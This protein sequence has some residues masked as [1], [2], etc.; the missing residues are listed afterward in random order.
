MDRRRRRVL[1]GLLLTTVMLLVTANPQPVTI[2]GPVDVRVSWLWSWLTAPSAFAGGQPIGPA[3]ES[4]TAAGKGHYVGYAATKASG[5]AGRVPDSTSAERQDGRVQQLT[6]PDIKGFEPGRSVR[7]AKDSTAGSDLFV[8]PDGSYTREVSQGTVN[9]QDAKGA[10]QKIDAR[11]TSVGERLGQRANRLGL[12]F[13]RRG[14]DRRLVSASFDGVGFGYSLQGASGVPAQTGAY[15]VTYAG[16]LPG[17]DVVVESRESGVKE[18]IVLQRRGAVHEWVFPLQLDGLVAAL[19]ADGGVVLTDAKGAVKG[20][21]PPGLMHDSKFDTASGEF[22]TSNAVRYELVQ[23][24]GGVGLKVIADEQWLTAP[25]RVYPVTVDPTAEFMNTSDTYMYYGNDVD[26]SGEDNLAVGTWDAGTHRGKALMAFSGFSSTFSGLRITSARLYLFLT[27]QGSCT[28]QPYTVHQVNESWSQST[29]R[30]GS[31]NYDGPAFSSA[32]GTQTPTNY[33]QACANTGGDRTVGEWTSV[34]LDK[35]TLDGWLSGTIPNYGL[36][37][38]A[39]PTQTADFKRFTSRN[40]PSGAVCDS[41][42]CAPFLSVS[43]TPNKAPQI[44]AQYPP[45]DYQATSLTPELLAKGHD[46]DVWPKAMQYNFKVNDAS[47]ALVATSGWTSSSSWTVPAGKLQWSKTY[48]WWVVSYDGWASSPDPLN[49]AYYFPLSTPPPQPLVTSGLSQ[50]GGGRG[51]EPSVGNYTTE[52]MDAQVAT[53]GPALTIQR[54]YN[55]RDP[56]TGSAF[57]AGWSTVVDA[58]V[59]ERYTTANAKTAVI[60]YPTGT[61]VAFGRNA[62]G[63]F[64]PPSGRFSVLTAI[65]GGYSLL[66]KDGTTYLFTRLVSGTAGANALYGL[67]SIKDSAGRALTFAYDAAGRVETMTSASGRALHLTWSTPAGAS[68]AHVATVYT[69]PAVAGDSSSVSIWSYAYSGDQ[70]T[71]VCPPT[72]TT[73]CTTYE[74]GTG[75]QYPTALL[76]AGPRSY[77]RLSEAAGVAKAASTVLDNAGTDAATFKNV[78]LGQAGSLP[79]SSATAAGFNGTSSY[80]EM[81]AKLVTAASYQSLSMWFKTTTPEG[82]LFSYQKDPITNGTTAANYVPALYVGTSGKLHAEFWNGASASAIASPSPVTDGAWHHVVLAAAGDTQTLY[83]DGTAVGTLAGLIKLADANSTAHEYVGAGFIGGSWPD[84]PHPS[85]AVA[86]YFSG[87]ISDVAL[88]D[89]TLT[90]ADV[91]SLRGAA[92]AAAHPVTKIIRPSGATAAQISYDPVSGVVTQVIDEHNGTWKISNPTVAG[93]SQ[94]YAASVLSGGPADYLRMTET[95]VSEAVNEVNGGVATYNTVTLGSPG[96]FADATAAKFNGTASYVELP[97]TEVPGTAPNSVSM[98]FSMPSGSTKGGVLYAYQSMSM[99]D[100]DAAGSWVPAL[101]VGVDGKLRGAFWTGSAANVLTT[102]ASVADG[103]WHHVALAASSTSQSLYLDGTLVGTR[104]AARVAPSTTPVYA[105]LGAG[106]WSSVWTGYDGD[107]SGYFPGSIGE[108]AFFTSQLTAAQ[109]ADQVAAG[110]NASATAAGAA[111]AKRIVVTD[112]LNATTTYLYDVDNGSRQVAEIWADGGSERQT[113]YGYKDGFLRTVTD[114]NGNVTTSEYDGRGNTVSEQTCQD[115]S[116]GRCSTVY[117]SYFLNSASALDPRNDQLTEVRDGRSAGPTDNTYVTKFEYDVLGNKT[118]TTDALGRIAKTD[119][120]DGTT[121][122]AADGGFAPAGLPWRVT[123]PGGQVQTTTYFANGDV[124]QVTDPAQLVTRLGYD[125]LGRVVSKTEISDGYPNGV[126]TRVVYDKLGRITQQTDPATT[127]RVTGAVHTPVTTTTYDYD[128]QITQQT[129]GDATG[130][131]AARTL[132]NSYDALGHIATAT[133]AT[134]KVTTFGYDLYGNLTREVDE[135]GVETRY[136][137]DANGHLLTSTLVGYTGDPNNPVSARD[138]VTESRAY[139]PAGRLAS[140][141]DAMGFVTAFLYTDNNL[142]VAVVKKNADGSQSYIAEQTEYD[143]AGNV[144]REVTNNNATETAYAVDAVGRVTEE[145]L[146]PNGVARKTLY[147]YNNDDQVTMKWYGDHTGYFGAV[148][149]TYD[150]AGRIT[151]DFVRSSGPLSPAG[152]WKLNATKGTSAVDS[153]DHDFTATATSGVTWSG[154]AA[155]FNG[156]TGWATTS[157]PVLDTTQSFSVMAWV[158]L[159]ANSAIQSVVSQDANVDSGFE[160]QYLKTENRWSFTRNLTDTTAASSSTAQ[161]TAA[162]TLNTWTHLV[163]VYNAADGKMTLYVNGAA[164]GTAADTTPIASSGSLAIGRSKYN[165]ATEAPFTGSIAQVQVYQRPLSASDVSSLYGRGW[166]EVRALG[167]VISSTSHTYDQRGL[168]LSEKDPL[169]N[170]EYYEYDESD[171]L[172]VTTSAP[173]NAESNGGTPVSSR[174]VTTTGFD[175]FGDEVELRDPD[176]NVTVITRD[177]SGQPVSTRLPNYT[178]PGGSPITASVSRTF[179]GSGNVASLTDALGKVTTYTYDQFGRL[180]KTAAPNGA[181]TTY[182]YDLN[183]ELLKTVDPLGAYSESTY[184][185]LGRKI[186]DSRFERSTSSTFTTSYAYSSAGFLQKAT[187][188]SGSYVT[189]TS[190]AAGDVITQADAAGNATQYAYDHL[191]R[192]VTVTAPDGS[193]RRMVYDEPGN[194]T[195]VKAYDSAGRLISKISAAY[196]GNGNQLSATDAMG[197]TTTFAYDAT[198]MVTGETQPVSATASITTSF[199]YDVQ[200]H[201]TRYT[202]GR[203]NRHIS[204][205]NSW[206]LLESQIEPATS[207]NPTDRTWTTSYDA[208]GRAVKQTQPGG[209]VITNGY[210]V[211]GNLTAQSGS[212]AEVATADRTFGYDLA[213]QLTSMKAGS[214]TDTFAYNDRGSLTTA[215]GPSGASSFAYNGDGLM[216]GRTDA[217]GTS[218]YSYD[219]VDRLAGV[220]DAATGQ[221][222]SYT[223]D[224]LSRLTKQTYGTG[225]YRSFGYDSASRLASDTLKTSAGATVASIAYGYDLDGRETSKTTTGFSGSAAHTYT[226]DW[227]GRLTS[228]NNGTTTT[229]YAYDA[230]GNRTRIGAKVMVYD[231]RDQLVGDGSTTY[232]YTARGTLKSTVAGSTTQT[233]TSDAY[234]QQTAIGSQAYTYDSLGRVLTAGST[235]LAYSGLDNDVAGDGAATYSRDPDGGVLGVK[236]TSG[237]GMFAW[238]DL[239]TDLVGQFSSTGAALAGSST[240]D[241]FGTVTATAGKVGNLGYQSEWTD[242]VANRVNMHARWYNPA[243]GQFDNRD[244]VDNDPIPDSI[245]ANH[246]Q[247]GDGNPLQ[248]IDSTGHWGWNPFKAVKKAVHKVTRYVSHTAYHYAYSHARSYWHAATHVVRH[249]VHHVKKAVHKV[250]RAVH[251]VYRSVKHTVYRAVHYAKRTYKKAVSTVKHTYHRVKHSVAKHINHIKSKVKNAYHRIK[252]AGSRIVAKVAKTV[253]AAANKVKDA[254]HATAKWVKEHKDTLIQ[255]GAIVAGVAAGIACTAVT[256]GAGAVACAVGAMALINLG[257]DAAQGNIHGFKDALGSLGQGALQGA[258]S[259]VTG[260]VGGVVAGKIAGALGAFGAK[261]GGR[262]I[263]GFVSGAGVDAAEQLATTR[264]VDWT[265]VAVAGGLGAVPGGAGRRSADD[266]PALSGRDP[267]KPR[268]ERDVEERR[269]AD[270][271][272]EIK[273]EVEARL[274]GQRAEADLASTIATVGYASSHPTAQHHMVPVHAGAGEGLTIIP[275]VLAIAANRVRL[276]RNP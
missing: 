62:D 168:P 151:S 78:T 77:W 140:I 33:S 71:K 234:G 65:T 185:Y 214:G 104:N 46:P 109:V 190:N 58:N 94:I 227:A 177:A 63:S 186:T 145:T 73:H 51:F 122:A 5:G 184:D 79:G 194:N 124:A 66:D 244:T 131:D 87:S 265:G 128:G 253:K 59:V 125:G 200:G 275:M 50:D 83:L 202:D 60:T 150:T 167:D 254:Y 266:G 44:D 69:D 108:F 260:G 212:G 208:A 203:G 16:V 211:V 25:E 76:D 153:S 182:A 142:Q 158:K 110:K 138:L 9:F 112:P 38:N 48:Y 92:S 256:A 129:V 229:S 133:D 36:L 22:T 159:G 231:E 191:G 271:R 236:P 209:V 19:D 91:A 10:W 270:E 267:G 174:P 132:K 111:L 30:Y 134:G 259:V 80:V 193:K 207:A 27:W 13:A 26:H 105:Y 136:A 258:L 276:W 226:Y 103:K 143:A 252:Q 205:Y 31:V 137:Y 57:G 93:S 199:G 175:T 45:R 183:D 40:G 11:V 224:G 53:V 98:W 42:T 43:Y 221:S 64:T 75:T 264:R 170:T 172:V 115:R 195:M 242:S 239:H 181:V 192:Q 162:P 269:K 232:S 246:Y 97:A 90:A 156:S 119:Y 54:S 82:V 121:I 18:S 21:I 160:L 81:P 178:P 157:E 106:K 161:S 217:S 250:S 72:D 219:T 243:T 120:T 171:N 147:S 262:M 235:S 102:A 149:S 251:R 52:A 29:V 187:R 268:T 273:D 8:N 84:Q 47:G 213:G 56:R 220:A 216:S 113:T 85:E 173:V 15:S 247:Y 144:I 176:G 166:S 55:S 248:T 152:W 2:F 233:L 23:V 163:G 148:G 17:T 179:D 61:E 100:V 154:G 14:D 198:G 28:A 34:A 188:P 237:A 88:F 116:A 49:V 225:D 249:V 32:I 201:R 1:A 4:G 96:P 218:T 107:S 204:T 74:Y 68:K 197:Q 189:Y 101:Y 39:S 7:S 95:G 139:D 155:A 255:I 164:Q 257:K 241:P 99:D 130:G 135:T 86:T 228:W 41:H 240:Y 67:T 12:Q 230:S 180:S 245:D 20:R 165:G 6:T 261:A 274:K 118:K 169:G 89:R 146:D 263:A 35:A 210:D 123:S 117:Y 37:V 206:G 24:G 272:T 3:Q 196:D 215:S 70:L 238:A 126:V 127:N 114:P 222:V 141:T 223:Y